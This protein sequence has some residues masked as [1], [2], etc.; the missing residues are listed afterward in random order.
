MAEVLATTSRSSSSSS[1]S[2]S[3]AA[4]RETSLA[5]RVVAAGS[6]RERL[7]TQTEHGHGGTGR[8]TTCSQPP[9]VSP[10]SS[11]REGE[12]LTFIPPSAREC[13]KRERGGA[14]PLSLVPVRRVGMFS[15]HQQFG[16]PQ[17]QTPQQPVQQ[18]QPQPP[19][20]QQQQAPFAQPSFNPYG[21]VYPPPF[22]GPQFG[23]GNNGL[24]TSGGAPAYGNPQFGYAPPQQ[25]QFGG[26]GPIPQ[27]QGGSQQGASGGNFGEKAGKRYLPGYLSS[28]THAQVRHEPAAS[29][30]GST[31]MFSHPAQAE[32]TPPQSDESNSRAWDSPAHRNS[33]SGSPISRFSQSLFGSQR[34]RRAPLLSARTCCSRA[35]S[36]LA[37]TVELRHVR[38]N[39]A[40]S[41]N[42]VVTFIETRRWTTTRRRLTPSASSMPTIPPCPSP[43]LPQSESAPPS[44]RPLPSSPLRAPSR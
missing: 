30:Q 23:G 10:E 4:S 28:G 17:Q 33:I 18:P 40:S 26:G 35:D 9:S 39:R 38:P 2:S 14:S 16:T 41:G 15:S 7:R 32:P 31:L 29:I 5:G 11:E 21:S 37:P 44:T 36:L 22:A 24:N 19:V 13:G 34:D 42:R 27:A 3:S 6:G 1:L 43:L 25:P 20:Q 12:E 8:E